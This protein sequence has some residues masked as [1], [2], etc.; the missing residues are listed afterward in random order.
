[1]NL[2]SIQDK[3]GSA[4][5]RKNTVKKVFAAASVACVA[6]VAVM[7]AVTL[8]KKPSNSQSPSLSVPKQTDSAS[9]G[10][11]AIVSSQTP[12][13]TPEND[14][15]Q[16]GTKAAVEAKMLLPVA[17]ANVLKGYSSEALVYSNTLKHWSTHMG[18]DL[19]ANEGAQVMAVLDGKVKSVV[20][21]ELMGLTITIE[22]ANGCSTVY[23]S[24]AG[25]ADG[26][27][28][29]ASVMRGQAI[30]TVGTSAAAES[31]DGA[32]LHFEVYADGAP[33][34]PQTYL[35]DLIK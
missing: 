21:D 17:S 2:G 11:N 24:L 35:S 4:V 18:L 9:V 31:S 34:N 15:Q 3:S 32:H 7:T 16:T 20:N 27:A 23:S 14:S 30:G 28:E 10:N 26:I 6:V 13:P 12:A 1:M 22:H 33:V 5:L 8:T 29:G 25:A 19:S